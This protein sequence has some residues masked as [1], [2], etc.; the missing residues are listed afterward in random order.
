M[1]CSHASVNRI[2][3]RQFI[4]VI[5]SSSVFKDSTR[6]C[7]N[8]DLFYWQSIWFYFHHSVSRGLIR[9]EKMLNLFYYCS[10]N[11]AWD[12]KPQSLPERNVESAIF[13]T[14]SS[15]DQVVKKKSGLKCFISLR[16]KTTKRFPLPINKTHGLSHDTVISALGLH[17]H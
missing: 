6:Y 16:L 7:K 11:I 17:F 5:L 15:V 2:N 14:Q 8:T 1:I 13:S 12:L 9:S 3:Y 10:F 4:S